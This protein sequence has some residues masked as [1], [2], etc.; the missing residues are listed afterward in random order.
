[1]IVRACQAAVP[2]LPE[3]A[4]IATAL[5]SGGRRAL[6]R[7]AGELVSRPDLLVSGRSD[8]SPT[9]QR[10][11]RGLRAQGFDRLQLP[12]CSSCGRAMW[13]SHRDGK[14]GKHCDKCNRDARNRACTSC[15]QRRPGGYRMLDGQPFCR[16]CFRR[17]PRSRET[18][19]V[20]AEKGEPQ[21][22]IDAGP[23]C[24]RCYSAPPL[25]CTLCRRERPVATRRD[26]QPLCMKC[27][28]ALRRTPRTCS[29]C[30]ERRISPHLSEQGPICAPCAGTDRSG[31][32][33]GCGDDQRRL[34]GIYCA[35]CIIPGK[36]RSLI[37]D[38]QGRPHR[39]L[40][41][42][43][44]YLL[45]DEENA[46]A[47]LS[48]IRRSPMSRVVHDMA[49]GR[50]PISLR[51]VAELPATG[52]SGYLAALLMESGVVPIE[53]FDR[54]RLEVWER[55]FLKTLVNPDIRAVLHR[56]AAWIV[57]PRF[58]DKA[59]LSRSDDSRRLGASKAH[60]T[61]V[62]ELLEALDAQGL[63]LGT[64]PQ[65]SFDDYVVARGRKGKELTPFV[66]WARSQQ[67]TR[68]RSEYLQ[69]SPGAPALSEDQ[70]WAWV[71]DLLNADDLGIASRVGGL[72]MIVYGI[73]A[74]RSVSIRR[75]AVDLAGGRT[76]ITLGTDPIELPDAIGALVR[77]LIDTGPALSKTD[78]IWLFNGRRAGRHLTTAA[79]NGPL[80]KRGINLRAG[81][82]AA[83]LNLARDVPASVL[84]DLLGI[85]IYAAERWGS[86]S[87]RDWVDYPRTR[88]TEVGSSVVGEA[89]LSEDRGSDWGHRR[90]YAEEPALIS[91]HPSAGV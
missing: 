73:T 71:K 70:R 79:L 90:N 3:S 75:D 28:Q 52:A 1:M 53:N 29:G 39:Q 56:Y 83:L 58:S 32:C 84:S 10:L 61:A 13:L 7:L 91:C 45:R 14:G 88:L 15:D 19:S 41:A 82:S 57:N 42:L 50:T 60:L 38:G 2:E 46:E 23:I 89:G 36:L 63:D 27:Y 34:N 44:Q 25:I 8:A 72:L 21:A 86:L 40:F 9:A 66:R 81:R 31:G 59:H 68:L 49:A 16:T 24:R 26:D 33:V 43:E 4:I 65:R 67:L 74:T 51:A 37:S 62:A 69:S 80:A 22:R 17:D 18:C 87:G 64:V 78:S 47:V 30:G 11:I 77:Q 76:R 55:E 12:R 6:T 54:V 5:D 85:S 48:W 20:C 35:R